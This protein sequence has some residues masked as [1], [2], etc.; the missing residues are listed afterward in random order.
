MP[1]NNS[2][3]WLGL[4][5]PMTA[6]P[7]PIALAWFLAII[8]AQMTAEQ[9]MRLMDT[10][11]HL[12]FQIPRQLPVSAAGLAI[13]QLANCNDNTLVIHRN[14]LPVPD[15]SKRSSYMTCPLLTRSMRF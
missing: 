15:T 9:K 5:A 13:R 1:K 7:A 11:T 10:G 3:D 14:R 2:F 12:I 8:R 4:V 6:A